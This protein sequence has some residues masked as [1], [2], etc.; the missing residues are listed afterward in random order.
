MT[1]IKFDVTLRTHRDVYEKFVLN[2]NWKHCDGDVCPFIL[3]GR[4]ISIPQQLMLEYNM[5][6]IKKN[7]G[8]KT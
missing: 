6:M 7:Q 5:Y 8:I 3:T 1:K 4:N 2:G